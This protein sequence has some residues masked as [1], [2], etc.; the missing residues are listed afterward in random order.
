VTTKAELDEV[1]RLARGAKNLVVFTGAGVSAESG[2]DTFRHE[3]GLWE[4]YPPEEFATPMG[5]VK[6]M[7]QDPARVARFLSDV[8]HPVAVARPNAGHVALARLEDAVRARG[9]DAVV[10]TQNVD[11]LHQDAGSK[12]VL[13]VH[14]SLFDV[15]DDEGRLRRRLE[16]AD[17]ERIAA[18]LKKAEGAFFTRTRVARALAPLFGV[19]DLKPPVSL[20]HRPNV[21]LF[22]E[23]LPEA[24][25]EQARTAAEQADLMLVVGTSGLVY[26]AAE[27]PELAARKGATVVGVG[28][29][30][31]DTPRGGLWLP[32]RAGEVLPRL[33]ERAQTSR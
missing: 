33:I 4:R 30:V 10:V 8:L 28:P 20:G 16:R 22:G 24:E 3:G 26:P 23:A 13:E 31:V 25:W 11:R 18:E 7:V 14:G 5:L 21:V 6:L 19:G 32:G 9:G 17:L 1:A 12:R 27:L 29:D 2:I 15:V